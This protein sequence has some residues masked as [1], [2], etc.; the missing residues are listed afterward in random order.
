MLSGRGETCDQRRSCMARAAAP[1]PLSAISGTRTAGSS[2]A[3]TIRQRRPT[4]PCWSARVTD[5]AGQ[6]L[7]TV[8]NYACHPTTLAW[9]NTLISPDF[10]A[11][12]GRPW[13]RPRGALASFSRG[14]GR[15][16]TAG[17]IRRR[18][19]RR[20]PQRPAARV[21]RSR[22]PRSVAAAGHALSV[23]AAPSFPALPSA[24][25]NTLPSTR[26]NDS[27]TGAG[28]GDTGRSI[29]PIARSSPR[30]KQLRP[31]HAHWLAEEQ[32]ARQAGD[33][34]KARDCRAMV[35]RQDRQSAAP[36]V[37]PPGKTFPCR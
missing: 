31:T 6:A 28:A 8:V 21:R 25:G 34:Q 18:R 30:W 14:F 33:L 22:R 11:P 2:S 13:S 24:P 27:N 16:G 15:P 37:L 3:A 5:E 7:A 26:N 32:A 4:T 10:P 29:L 20:G 17:R 1:W 36:Q 19:G 35:E 9:Q 12:C 23:H